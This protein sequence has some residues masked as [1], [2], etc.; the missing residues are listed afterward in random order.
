MS[1]VRPCALLLDADHLALRRQ[2]RQDLPEIG[3]DVGE[4][5][6]Q[7]QQRHATAAVNLVIHV[8]TI[9]VGV[10]TLVVQW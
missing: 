9:E 2:Q 7:E 10:S 5:A 8:Q 1:A 6:V 3:L 4:G